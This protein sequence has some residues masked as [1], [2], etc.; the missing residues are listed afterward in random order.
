MQLKDSL[1]GALKPVTDAAVS[2]YACGITPY[3]SAH[4]GHARTYV[5]FD[6]LAQVLRAEGH[7]VRLVRNI[8]DIDD[9][10]IAAAKAA[11]MTWQALSRHYAQENRDLMVATGLAVPEEP[12]A[13]EYLDDIFW[14][15]GELQK[16]GLA[17]VSSTGDVLYRVS[18]YTGSLLMAHKEGA[19]RSEAGASRVSTDGKEDPR[20][21]ALW[22]RTLESEPGFASPWGWGRPGW[23]I[24][25]S[26][27]IRALFGGS[28]S[29]HGGGVDLKFPHHQAEI[30]QSEPVF[31]R[32]LADVWMHNGSVHSDGHKMSKSEGNFVTWA[33]ALEAAN[34]LAPGLGGQLLKFALLQAHWQ[35]P[36]DW[37]DK[38]LTTTLADLLQ[39]T[40]GLA[41][42]TVV[43]S[44]RVL[45]EFE[46]ALQANLNTPAA[47]TALKQAHKRGE[48]SQV[49]KA[50]MFL[51]IDVLSWSRIERAHVTLN[52]A[53]IEDVQERRRQAR[54]DKNWGLADELRQFLQ[55]H[56]V[57]VRDTVV[58]KPQNSRSA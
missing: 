52:A 29:I 17:Y 8:T 1:T 50:L 18:S 41:A 38:L 30:M 49:A 10:I 2:I 51:G 40:E 27:M 14:L 33:A 12:K 46:V 35:K 26:A 53:R 47:I 39:L 13:S 6:L 22:K 15:V 16:A 21:F 55:A 57:D 48:R 5:V 44:A 42:E 11:G 37:S 20:D 24:E 31:G 54:A 45:P 19:L 9:K 4:V 25:C 43:S 3:S 36:L 32:P 7:A 56:G 23:H 34:Q 28:V 58:S